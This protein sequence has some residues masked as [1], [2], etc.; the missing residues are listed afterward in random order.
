MKKIKNIIIF[1]DNKFQKTKNENNQST[2]KMKKII[3]VQK[4]EWM[5]L[6]LCAYVCT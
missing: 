2:R 1:S 6:W 3:K 4:N 5:C